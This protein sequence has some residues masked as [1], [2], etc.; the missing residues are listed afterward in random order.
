MSQPFAR[1]SAK[2]FSNMESAVAADWIHAI[3]VLDESGF[4][5]DASFTSVVVV[6]RPTDVDRDRNRF[7]CWESLVERLSFAEETGHGFGSYSICALRF[8]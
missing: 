2:H 1:E 6:A 4:I 8:V 5:E 7:D 3:E